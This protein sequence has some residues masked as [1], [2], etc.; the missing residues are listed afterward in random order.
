M[1]LLLSRSLTIVGIDSAPGFFLFPL[2]GQ[3]LIDLSFMVSVGGHVLTNNSE[4]G[5]GALLRL[6]DLKHSIFLRFG[7]FAVSAKIVVFTD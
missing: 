5:F 4:D 1:I 3:L 2:F 7:G 6:V